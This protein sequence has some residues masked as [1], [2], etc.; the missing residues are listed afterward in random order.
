M[1]VGEMHQRY[2]VTEVVQIVE[3]IDGRGARVIRERKAGCRRD[4]ERMQEFAPCHC[5]GLIAAKMVAIVIM[6][7]AGGERTMPRAESFIEF[8]GIPNAEF[9]RRA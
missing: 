6:P 8:K 9:A 3:S 1:A 4:R 2:V 7:P 5:H